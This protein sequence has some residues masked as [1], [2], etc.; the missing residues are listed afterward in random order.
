MAEPFLD[1]WG[2]LVNQVAGTELIFLALSFITILVFSVIWKFDNLT[3]IMILA[4]WIIIVSAF[5]NTLLAIAL[6]VIGYFIGQQINRL[7]TR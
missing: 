7:V 6:V 1:V 3:T 2:V 5:I 4:V